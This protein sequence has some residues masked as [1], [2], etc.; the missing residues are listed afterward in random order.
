MRDQSHGRINGSAAAA[1]AAVCERKLNMTWSFERRRIPAESYLQKFY[2]QRFANPS[3]A[4]DKK[5]SGKTMQCC[6]RRRRLHQAFRSACRG[7]AESAGSC[8]EAY[9]R[10]F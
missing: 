9:L 6:S 3:S 7:Q 2:A 4:S 10:E 8:E 5:N 1:F